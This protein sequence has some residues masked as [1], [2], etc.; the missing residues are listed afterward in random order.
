M[1][2]INNE[3]IKNRKEKEIELNKNNIK[4]IAI[5]LKRIK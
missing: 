4:T 3:L 2:K 1:I 5:L